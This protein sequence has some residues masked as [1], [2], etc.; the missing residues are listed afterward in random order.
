MRRGPDRHATT[1]PAAVVDEGGEPL[2]L[3]GAALPHAEACVGGEQ[4][5][6]L[7]LQAVELRPSGE[8][9]G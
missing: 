4:R 7:R 3:T 9:V 5:V 1:L 6:P 2:A 8:D